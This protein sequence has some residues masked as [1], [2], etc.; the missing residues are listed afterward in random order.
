MAGIWDG[1]RYGFS[2]VYWAQVA[3]IP[4]IFSERATGLTLPVGWTS[5]DA[6]LV[7]DSSA[8]VGIEQVNRENGAAVSLGLSFKLLDTTA[9]RT[10]L[11]QPGKSMRLTADLA[12]A[13]TSMTVDNTTGW[14]NGD[15]AWLGMERITIG[16]VA[17]GTSCT[18]LG[19]GTVGTWAYD[20]ATG[21]TAQTI[22]DVPRYWRGREVILYASPCDA[23]GYCTGS[24][25]L[26]D[27]VMVWRGK[28][29]E[30]PRRELDG[31]SFEASSIDRFS[32]RRLVSQISGQVTDTSAK[33]AASKG[34]E[35]KVVLRANQSN[36]TQVFS[37]IF[38]L[39]PFSS[40]ADGDLLSMAE[41]RDRIVSAFAQAVADESAGADVGE[42]RWWKYGSGQGTTYNGKVLVKADATITNFE[43]FVNIDGKQTTAT[44]FDF[45]NGWAADGYVDLK[46]QTQSNPLAPGSSAEP[47]I[48]WLVTVRVD[49][50]AAADVPAAGG[51]VRIQAG[52]QGRVFKYDAATASAADVY[53]TGLQPVDGAQ[54]WPTKQQMLG[55]DAQIL[56]TDADTFPVMMLRCLMS[57]GNGERSATYD[58]LAR[59]QG[60]GL[61][62]TLISAPSFTTTSAPLGTLKGEV[63]SAG[64]SFSSL[65]GGAMGL[66]RKAVVA[67][68]DH[69]EANSPLKLTLVST[70]P[71]GADYSVT[72]ADTDLLSH[73]G[74]PVVSVKRADS[75][76]VLAILRPFG[77]A[78]DGE[79]RFVFADNSRAD[80]EGRDQVEYRVPAKD[81]QGLYDVA[82]PAAAAHLAADQ[83]TQALQLLAPPWI[84]ADVGDVVWLDITHPAVWTW[85]SN[86]GA[87]GY[88]GAARVVGRTIGLKSPTV[89]LTL[90]IDASIS[91]TSLS[92]AAKIDAFGGAAAAPTTIDVPLKYKTHFDAALAD[93]GAN[94]W[95]YH[96]QPGQVET[97]TQK[98]E[99]SAAAEV[100]GACQLTV[101][102]TSGGHS[103]DL[104]KESTITLPTTSGGD[105]STYQGRFAHTDDGTNWG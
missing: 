75:A 57:S 69:T 24:A 8:A 58:T 52:G 60:Y 81:R 104:T 44:W 73:Q 3:G 76:N 5:E 83:T 97:A 78:Q 29:E 62:E 59:G 100:G 37:Y 66:F 15:P 91:V 1:V 87:P 101:A 94:V 31:F 93:A 12:A 18:G 65:F 50:G 11:R 30:G 19:R 47:V 74:D 88:T 53:L 13:A 6:S 56:F 26:D 54:G 10:W 90:L 32:D 92:P 23:A 70:A 46:W 63:A 9:V 84:V 55:A 98:H 2:P 16:T 21:T 85:S 68:P 95:A 61:D 89:T 22:T 102:S 96:Y 28:I 64:E 25:L 7:V 45:N 20:H 14:S 51:R 43:V 27:A 105:I 77:G 80:A 39:N 40:D 33:L 17:S 49:Q 86:P 82:G 79:D 36:G 34:L 71:Y 99:I 42:F 38:T 35:I 41:V 72:V 103:L 67:R 48:P 4:V